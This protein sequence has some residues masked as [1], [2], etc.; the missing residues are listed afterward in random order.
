MTFKEYLESKKIDPKLLFE[1]DQDLFNEWKRIFKEVSP[2]SFTQQKLFIIN[3][4][5]R[6]FPLQE[7]ETNDTTEVK[8]APLKVKIGGKS[9]GVK[10]GKKQ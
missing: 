9:L 10:I 6:K 7:K 2:K 5:R 3:K 8:K 4:T 1:G